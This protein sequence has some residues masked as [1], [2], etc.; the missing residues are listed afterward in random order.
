M[1]LVEDRLIVRPLDIEVLNVVNERIH[2]KENVASN[3][4]LTNVNVRR[5]P[6]DQRVAIDRSTYENEATKTDK[7]VKVHRIDDSN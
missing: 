4:S 7:I 1:K 5:S 2:Q 3:R 6:F